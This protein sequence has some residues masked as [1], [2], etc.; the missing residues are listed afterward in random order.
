MLMVKGGLDQKSLGTPGLYNT[1]EKTSLRSGASENQVFYT[2]CM[3]IMFLLQV[4]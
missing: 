4:A 2:Q 3:Q 1:V